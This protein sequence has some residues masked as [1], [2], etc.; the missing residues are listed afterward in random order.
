MAVLGLLL[1]ACS[2]PEPD[3]LAHPLDSGGTLADRLSPQ[4][5]VVVLVIRPSDAFTCGSHISRW[6]EWGRTR[7]G[8]FLLVFSR[9]PAPAE[10]RQPLLHRLRPD[11]VLA[12]SRGAART[13]VPHE[14]LITQR[15]V[16]ISH[17]VQPGIPES[18]LLIAMEQG[19]VAELVHRRS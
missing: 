11:A 17:A 10:R 6:M 7:R 3:V 1:L 15:R 2:H 12:S 8:Q 9:P 18:P 14:Y 19:R 4:D 5:S 13:P 16:V